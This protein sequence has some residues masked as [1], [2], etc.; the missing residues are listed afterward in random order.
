MATDGGILASRASS[1]RA[2]TSGEA[3]SDLP[4]VR[5]VEGDVR[6]ERCGT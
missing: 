3:S 2:G 6:E 5:R 4:V 1:S